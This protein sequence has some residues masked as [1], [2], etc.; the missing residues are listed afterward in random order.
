M[1][2]EGELEGHI[3]VWAY[4]NWTVEDMTS[5]ARKTVIEDSLS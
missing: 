5:E 1:G 2:V 3:A 4:E